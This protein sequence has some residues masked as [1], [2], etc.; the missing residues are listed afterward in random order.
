VVRRTRASTI[1]DEI[2]KGT[3]T[4]TATMSAEEKTELDNY[5]Q[6]KYFQ[7]KDYFKLKE[8]DDP[9]N[10]TRKLYNTHADAKQKAEEDYVI[11][12]NYT[13]KAYYAHKDELKYGED[14]HV[15]F[16]ILYDYKYFFLGV[17]VLAGIFG[18]GEMLKLSKE[19]DAPKQVA[20]KAKA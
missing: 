7:N 1:G 20:K 18:I 19:E 5:F 11:F 12:H 4:K 14:R 8:D 2:N 17:L 3:H 10:F 15:V 16:G 9:W 6:K 13:Y